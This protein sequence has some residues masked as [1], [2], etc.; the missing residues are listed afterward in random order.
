MGRENSPSPG[1]PTRRRQRARQSGAI[2]PPTAAHTETITVGRLP[3]VGARNNAASAR[4][5]AVGW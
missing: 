1:D 3:G 5:F 2:G 4:I